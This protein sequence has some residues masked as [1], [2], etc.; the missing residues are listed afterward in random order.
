MY[1]NPTLLNIKT[2]CFYIILFLFNCNLIAENNFKINEDSIQ[3]FF[4]TD[5]TNQLVSANIVRRSSDIFYLN[6][7]VDPQKRAQYALYEVENTS[8]NTINAYVKADNFIGD[9]RLADNET[10]IYEIG[11]LAVGEK[12]YA[13]IYIGTDL[14]VSGQNQTVSGT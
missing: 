2:F 5:R 10:G 6:D 11:N 1:F 9:I 8:I 7:D 12:G 14:A 3:H 13:Y 4:K